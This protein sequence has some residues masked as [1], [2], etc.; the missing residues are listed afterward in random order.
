MKKVLL[1]AKD[2]SKSYVSDR[3]QNHVINHLDLSIYEGDFTVVMGPSGSGKSTLLYC[4]S[5]MEEV[6][7]GEVQFKDEK[8]SSLK[9]K[10]LSDIR[11]YRFGFVFQQIHLVSNLSL[12]ENVVLPGY[13]TKSAAGQ[14]VRDRA[15]D[16]LE[17]FQLTEAKKRLP[18]QVSGGE[19]QRAAIA[20]ALINR[21]ELL[22]ADEPTGALNRKNSDI[23]L[24]LFSKIHSEGQSIV[25]VTH[26]QRAALRANRIIYIVDGKVKGDLSLPPYQEE[27]LEARESQVSAWL[28]SLEW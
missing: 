21:P 19:Q 18:S 26:D 10:E 4:L 5:G 20:R 7:G 1:E 2:L 9:E 23:I 22:F 11:L 8:I 17:Q 12:F 6:T 28:R 3:V 25:M 14:A 16:L 24:D 15:D 13:L 27:D